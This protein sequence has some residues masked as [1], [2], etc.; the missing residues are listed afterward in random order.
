M[1]IFGMCETIVMT[2]NKQHSLEKK[3]LD[4]ISKENIISKEEP[5][6][7]AIS[8]GKDSICLFH[9]LYSLKFKF[10]CAHVNFKLRGAES[11]KDEAFVKALCKKYNVTL[12]T[13]H[14]NTEALAKQNKISTQMAAR[15]LRYQWF[16]T[17]GETNGYAK[18]VTAHHLMD[19]TETILLNLVRGSSIDGLIG[20]K[21]IQ[22]KI[23]R[24][25]L[26][27]ELEEILSY[28]KS[29][30]LK[31][32]EDSSNAS[33]KYK[34]N[35]IRHKVIPE[36]QKLNP[37]LN[38]TLFDNSQH[39]LDIQ[40]FIQASFQS[41]KS[42]F[43]SNS[44]DNNEVLQIHT[45]I[46]EC[47]IHEWLKPYGFNSEQIQ[48]VYQLL[49]AESGKLISN[50]Q[51]QVSKD[52]QTLILSKTIKAKTDTV[53][54]HNLNDLMQYEGF[55]AEV[56]SR[57]KLK[58]LKVNAHTALFDL[59]KLQFPL[60]LINK[61][62][63]EKFKPLGL[64]HFVKVSDFLIQKKVALIEKSKVNLL[65]QKDMVIWVLKMRSDNRFKVDVNTQ[66]VL[67]ITCN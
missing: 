55:D 2:K 4:F 32:R 37:N 51:Y 66:T 50:K 28:L 15:E 1:L 26:F 27:A 12:H 47:F 53:I 33:I 6:L 8:G 31:F 48:A 62:Q 36:L 21:P 41:F 14:F 57:N 38:Q 19:N 10:A 7:L 5:L 58:S 18:I 13:T 20:I 17:L 63:N 56:M 67:K 45:A 35:S 44:E 16:Q 23:A 39:L 3:F 34:R 40:Q 60:T 52:R 25:L 54:F 42:Y 29:S 46:P 65:M 43:V 24:P 30:R 9:L 61:Y 64:N 22:Q 11:D 49:K 59:D